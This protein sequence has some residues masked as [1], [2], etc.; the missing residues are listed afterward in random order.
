MNILCITS[1]TTRSQADDPQTY[2]LK[3]FNLRSSF[4]F[5]MCPPVL[6]GESANLGQI[7][8]SFMQVTRL[9]GL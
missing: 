6:L 9:M 4:A 7:G 8:V 3:S 1:V 2:W 5:C